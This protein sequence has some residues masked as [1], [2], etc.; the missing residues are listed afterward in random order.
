MTDSDEKIRYDHYQ[1]DENPL[2]KRNDEYDEKFNSSHIPF[3]QDNV[4]G[5]DVDDDD[6]DEGNHY[7]YVATDNNNYG[8]NSSHPSKRG[9]RGE[10]GGGSRTSSH[11][12][13]YQNVSIHDDRNLTQDKLNAENNPNPYQGLNMDMD[14]GED[15]NDLYDD[16]RDYPVGPDHEEDEDNL[17]KNKYRSSKYQYKTKRPVSS[18]SFSNADPSRRRSLPGSENLTTMKD[19]TRPRD[20][21]A[22]KRISNSV[23]NFDMNRVMG[24][25]TSRRLDSMKKRISQK[26]PRSKLRIMNRT[27]KSKFN[28]NVI[29]NIL[30]RLQVI[31]SE[32]QKYVVVKKQQQQQQ[33]QHIKH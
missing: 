27:I 26:V 6:D 17:Y 3:I 22:F 31:I 1:R 5:D 23:Q 2:K 29:Y 30:K 8:M 20:R 13:S 16:T 12:S 10:G 25:D 14:Q 28:K 4:N 24:E 21:I 33:Q 32:I 15:K 18:S 19:K 11:S 9:N 7:S